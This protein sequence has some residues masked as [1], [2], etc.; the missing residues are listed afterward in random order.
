MSKSEGSVERA[1][2][3][4]RKMA[5]DFEFKPGE[6]LNESALT[7]TFEV[8]RT[9]LREALNRLVAEGFLTFDLGR[10]FFCRPLSP[11]KILELYQLRCALETEA[12]NRTI[13]NA[14]DQKIEAV[15]S[16]LDE[17][18]K[19]YSVCT[20]LNEL[21]HMDEEFHVK[22]ASLS[23]NKE[24]VRLLCNVNERIR[25]VRIINLRLLRDRRDT[26]DY[27]HSSMSQHRIIL[28][29]VK[30]RDLHE[31]TKALRRHIERRSEQTIE[32]VRVAY[33]QLYVPS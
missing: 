3:A 33:S 28:N 18:E 27:E 10:G 16:Y 32:L 23:G 17:A 24:L 25:Y 19:L 14:D 26:S 21:L 6:R 12:L 4:L 11:D 5:I 2:E 7:K 22:L 29:A 31:A 30:A 13:E 9:P 20:D 8:S 15:V 1:Y